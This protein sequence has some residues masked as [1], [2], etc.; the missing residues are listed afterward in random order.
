MS[1]AAEIESIFRRELERGGL[2][3]LDIDF[4][5]RA[6]ILLARLSRE[7]RDAKG[8]EAEMLHNELMYLKETLRHLFLIR[9][10]K[11][12]N[13]VWNTGK[14]P[15]IQLPKEEIDVVNRVLDIL[16]SIVVEE[17]KPRLEKPAPLQNH[18]SFRE[19]GARPHLV[20][21]SFNKP[22]TRIL[23]REGESLGPFSKGH[24]ALLP[25]EI[26]NELAKNGTVEILMEF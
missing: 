25:V 19:E 18:E 10:I 12:L 24:V 4:Y 7:A 9:I 14:R 8:L 23:L 26:A 17:A 1:S 2:T 3:S 11:I 20:L 15:E 13:D 6:K 21:V 22:Y 16:S 5:E